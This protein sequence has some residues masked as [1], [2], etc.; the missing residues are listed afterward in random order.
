MNILMWTACSAIVMQDIHYIS[1]RKI[2]LNPVSLTSIL[3][4][5][6]WIFGVQFPSQLESMIELL[7]NMSTPLCMLILGMRLATMPLR[8][9]FLR[10]VLYGAVAIK[11][12]VFPLLI[13]LML[14]LTPFD[15]VLEMALFILGC[16]PVASG[17]LNISEL[18]G[19]GQDKAAGTV[20]LGT[21]LSV[22]TIPLM[23]L[24]L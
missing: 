23:T 19:T 12:L 14:L 6:L 13:F 21:S 18:L 3:A 11:Q 8:D 5:P 1:L 9:I 17:V 15:P 2:F 7:G 22:L 16:C 4:L 10:P 24:L 20:L